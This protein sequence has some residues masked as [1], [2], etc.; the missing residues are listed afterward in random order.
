MG[1]SGQILAY[2]GLVLAYGWL[3]VL[4]VR[5]RLVRDRSQRVLEALLTVS[6]LWTLGLGLLEFL[7]SDAWWAYAWDRTAQLGLILLAAI[8]A[9]FAG[10]FVERTTSGWLRPALVGGLAAAVMALAL[11]LLSIYLPAW[12]LS[13]GGQ[14]VGPAELSSLLLLMAWAIPTGAAWW[15]AFAA[16]G[17]VRGS[18]H[19]NR[20]QYLVACLPL[21]LAGDLVVLFTGAP[22]TLLGS[23]LRLI[24]L[25]IATFAVVRHDLP[26]LRGRWLAL[27]R[28]ALSAGFTALLYFAVLLAATTISGTLLR[29]PR[30]TVL[31][32]AVC[33]AVLLAALVGVVLGPSVQRFIDRAL[34]GRGYEAQRALRSYSQ[35]VNLILDLERL[36]D[37][38]LDWLQDTLDVRSSAFILVTPRGASEVELRV[39][40]TRGASEAESMI[41]EADSRFLAHFRNVG[42]PLS[43]YDVDRLTWFHGMASG[44]RSWLQAQTAE[45]YIPLLVAD[46]PAAL[47]ALGTKANTQSYSDQELETLML[48]A[49]QTATALENARL[50]DDLRAVQGDLKRLN[51]ELAETNRQLKRLDEAKSDFVTI[52]SHELRTPLSQIFGYSDVLSSLEAEELSDS[53]VVNQFVSGIS[54]GAQRLKRVVDALVDMSMIETGMLK[55]HTA[56]TRMEDVLGSTVSTFRRVAAGRRQTITVDTTSDLPVIDADM[57]RLG[58]VFSCLLSNAIKFSPDGGCITVTARSDG[59]DLDP[60]WVEVSVADQGIGIDSEQSQL[61]FEKFYR[62]ENTMFHSTDEVSFKGAGPGLGL[63]IARGIV[64]AHGGRIWV[65]SPGRDEKSCPGSAFFVRLPVAAQ[66]EEQGYGTAD[67]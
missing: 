28:L 24:G 22:L 44:E 7:G 40:G 56:P 66:L 42:Q 65:E 37:T 15:T 67:D 25:T 32:P 62:P 30:P 58:Q 33:I 19:R 49:D 2:A 21:L 54:R 53:Q 48:L 13:L 63:A 35:Q 11:D 38:T 61:I 23:G 17:E 57:G 27:V 43:Q 39:L 18:K 31:L 12:D 14:P 6:T 46:R 8:T 52:A 34:Y 5:R 41:F 16:M 3:L 60:A 51:H 55:I 45:V 9:E 4:A 26:D 10:A 36:A 50:M 29:L 64:E 59:P 47:L 1:L 20:L